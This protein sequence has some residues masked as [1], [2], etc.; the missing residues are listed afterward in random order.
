MKPRVLFLAD[1]GP[2]VGGGHVMRCLSL[3]AAL[4]RGGAACAV[5][6]HPG[7]RA[8]LSAFATPDIERLEVRGGAVNALVTQAR[9]AAERW[10]AGVLVADHYELLSV[11]EARLRSDGRRIV[12]IDD[13]MRPAHDCDLLVDPSFGRRAE[14][15]GA[16][17]QGGGVVLA[18]PD[19]ALLRDE[20]AAGREQALT[21]RAS[22]AP[23]RR[24]LVAL[25]LTDVRGITGRVLQLLRPELG[26]LEVDVAVGAGAPSL[27]WLTHLKSSDPRIHV[28]VD[29]TGMVELMTAADLAVGAG[30]SSVWERACLGLPSVN[31]VLAE[32]QRALADALDGQGACLAVD[33]SRADFAKTLPDAFARL[34]DDSGLRQSL[35]KTS[36]RLCDGGGAERVAEAILSLVG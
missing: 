3:A 33:A 25:G 30:G 14:D 11:H 12:V 9:D 35:S 26:E 6:D 8:V 29:T 20:F 2:A 31:V 19:Y 7:A 34:R 16:V 22:G 23:V 32:N 4:T 10:G 27:P 36:A 13:L 1:G 24:L 17:Q 21:G 15:Y 28:H 18:G 5:I